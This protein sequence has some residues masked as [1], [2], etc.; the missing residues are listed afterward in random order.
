MKKS[1]LILPIVLL[2]LTARLHAQGIDGCADSPENPT[3]VLGLIVGAASVGYS[4]LRYRRRGH[5]QQGD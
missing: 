5:N 1:R 3:L 2:I 4:R